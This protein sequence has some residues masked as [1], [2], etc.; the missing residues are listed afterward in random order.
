MWIRSHTACVFETTVS[1]AS[2]KNVS[3]ILNDWLTQLE[4]VRSD[5]NAQKLWDYYT[6]KLN[7][8]RSLDP[9]RIT[10]D[11][12]VSEA[13]KCP[14]LQA[15]HNVTDFSSW[16]FKLYIKRP[17]IYAAIKGITAE[18]LIE[19]KRIAALQFTSDYTVSDW[20]LEYRGLSDSTKAGLEISSLR[21]NG[22]PL[23]GK[24]DLVF[25]H[26]HTREIVILEI[27]ASNANVPG[28]GWPNLR[29]QLWAYGQ[30]DRYADSPKIHLASQVWKETT[31]GEYVISAPIRFDHSDREFN[32]QNALLFGIYKGAIRQ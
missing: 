14:P 6:G 9:Y 15:K 21:I 32:E 7:V 30:I 11:K 1:S 5:I 26:R 23:R 31:T 18:T 27:K 25:K 20:T 17:S 13:L 3:E 22:Q 28:N 19:K 10:P 29:A 4:N 16:V 24:P 8:N 12:V 2:T